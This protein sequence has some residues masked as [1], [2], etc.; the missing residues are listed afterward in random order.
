MP[1]KAKTSIWPW[2]ALFKVKVNVNNRR[3]YQ[4]RKN[5]SPGA[6]W[7]LLRTDAYL[8]YNFLNLQSVFAWAMGYLMNGLLTEA[9]VFLH[10]LFKN[11]V[12]SF[13]THI[14]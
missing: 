1:I 2:F 3:S 12:K 13:R 7:V 6:L 9:F 4:E 11:I 10:L 5:L 8:I 14:E